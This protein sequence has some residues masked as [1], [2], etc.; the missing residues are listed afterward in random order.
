MN[1]ILCILNPPVEQR[2]PEAEVGRDRPAARQN[3]GEDCE[4]A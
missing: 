4:E 3:S 1:L 2:D